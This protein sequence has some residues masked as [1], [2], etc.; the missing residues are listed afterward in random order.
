MDI[1]SLDLA[2]FVKV[3]IAIFNEDWNIDLPNAGYVCGNAEAKSKSAARQEENIRNH[4]ATRL[5]AGL[6]AQ[7]VLVYSNQLQRLL[8]ATLQTLPSIDHDYLTPEHEHWAR[9]LI[10]SAGRCLLDEKPEWQDYRQTLDLLLGGITLARWAD[11][12]P[13]SGLVH[14]S[15]VPDVQK[16]A[17]KALVDALAKIRQ[18]EQDNNKLDGLRY[19]PTE[20]E[21]YRRIVTRTVLDL[22][23]KLTK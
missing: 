15:T 21:T 2:C 19:T 23:A 7:L 17:V 4:Q 8:Y 12:G 3:K 22:Q 20:W 5:S 6:E 13:R 11:D 16:D 10:S 18:M 1:I 9:Q 14:P